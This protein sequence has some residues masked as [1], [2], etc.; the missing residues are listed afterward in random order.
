MNLKY[1]FNNQN[2]LINYY[3]KT[4]KNLKKGIKG[5]RLKIEGFTEQD[6]IKENIGLKIW[7]EKDKFTRFIDFKKLDKEVIEEVY[8]CNKNI[9]L[10]NYYCREVCKNNELSF[11]ETRN[12][13]IK[14]KTIKGFEEI[15]IEIL[16]ILEYDPYSIIEDNEK[17]EEE[18]LWMLK[19]IHYL[20]EARE[21]LNKEIDIGYDE[22]NEEMY[23]RLIGIELENIIWI[24]GEK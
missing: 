16:S 4:S 12:D 2:N 9:H 11:I 5:I 1:F 17:F 19:N 6:F 18:R 24:V 7:N 14:D 8:N 10:S 3:I 21:L 22:E 15:L 13:I 20:I 23:I